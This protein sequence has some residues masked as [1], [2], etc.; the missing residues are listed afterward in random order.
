MSSVSNAY[1]LE[2]WLRLFPLPG[3]WKVLVQRD[4]RFVAE[5]HGPG[6]GGEFDGG[7]VGLRGGTGD[8]ISCQTG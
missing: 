1:P 3:P 7:W 4:S 5:G 6:I 2:Y 8:C